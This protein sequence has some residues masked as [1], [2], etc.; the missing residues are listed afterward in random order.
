MKRDVFELAKSIA[1]R[2]QIDEAA[3]RWIVGAFSL[4]Y[5]DGADPHRI[6]AYLRFPSPKR[7]AEAERN[8]WLRQVADELPEG[9]RAAALKHLM[10]AFMRE[11]WPHWSGATRPPS[12]ATEID[13]GL[14][15]AAATG[16]P[17]DIGRHQIRKI[18]LR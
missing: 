17:M 10:L 13:A 9:H 3:E 12:D 2:R 7:A 18:L 15:F 5:D 8:R 11:R 4:W 1:R 14:F 16:A 6:S